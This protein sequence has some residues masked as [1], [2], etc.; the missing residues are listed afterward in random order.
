[1]ETALISIGSNVGSR[2][3]NCLVSIK[4]LA[5]RGL[6]IKGVSPWFITQPL[7][8]KPQPWFVNGVVSVITY[9]D[10][11]SLLN[12]LQMVESLMGRQQKGEGTARFIDLD[13]VLYDKLHLQTHRLT[14]PH[15]GFRERR[16]VLAPLA[17]LAPNAVDPVTGWSTKKLLERCSDP[18]R[19]VHIRSASSKAAAWYQVPPV[20][21]RRL[22]PAFEP[23]L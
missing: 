1:M 8:P 17:A 6:I 11:S 2:L 5:L 13:I 19:V 16:F 7:S 18:S 20:P 22:P 4:L 3:L 10:P 15:P 9:L 14:I 21:P 12:L 23:H